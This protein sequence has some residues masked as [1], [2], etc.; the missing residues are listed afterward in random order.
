MKFELAVA[1]HD[2][3]NIVRSLSDV[4]RS[5][6]RM[7]KAPAHPAVTEQHRHTAVQ[8]LAIE[9]V[10]S[11]D[12]CSKPSGS[13]VYEAHKRLW[14]ELGK[15]VDHGIAIEV[16]RTQDEE[17]DLIGLSAKHKKAA[18]RRLIASG[19]RRLHE[20]AIPLGSVR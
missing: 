15:Q 16:V 7:A 1:T 8:W 20:D 3:A 14:Q 17:V 18:I 6:V 2:V 11:S 9:V 5:E 12:A 10:Y 19:M 13:A 4:A